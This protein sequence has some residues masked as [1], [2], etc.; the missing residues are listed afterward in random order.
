MS[1][2]YIT[3]PG[4]LARLDRDQ[5][6]ST[7]RDLHGCPIPAVLTNPPSKER[8]EA[9]QKQIDE[10]KKRHA[11]LNRWMNVCAFNDVETI[12]EAKEV[13]EREYC[14]ICRPGCNHQDTCDGFKKEVGDILIE[15][16]EAG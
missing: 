1:G 12:E 10:S 3:D 6:F 9:M 16:Q 2:R 8:I 14:A 4:K 13:A 5:I 11:L 15:W 7:G